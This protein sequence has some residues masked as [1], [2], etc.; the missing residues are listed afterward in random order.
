MSKPYVTAIMTCYNDEKYVAVA[1]KSL[2]EQTSPPDV[3]FVID[4]ASTDD[5]WN[6]LQ[7]LSKEYTSLHISQNKQNIGT[8]KSRNK[9]LG[10]IPE[11]TDYIVILDSDD[12]ARLDRIE[13][14]VL[15]LDSHP[16]VSAIN[17]DIEIIN[18]F[19]EVVGT[20]KHRPLTPT[21]GQAICW[22][23]FAQSA[24]TLRWQDWQKIGIYDETLR[25]GEDYDMW[26]RMLERGQIIE[27]LPQV[28]VQFRVHEGQGKWQKSQISMREYARVRARYL[29]KP[30]FFSVKALVI[31]LGY[32][33]ASFIPAK[34][35]LW[36]YTHLYARKES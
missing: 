29:F 34:I 15:Y 13:K 30:G 20:K 1:L 7:A 32:F 11:Q 27:I 4:D 3:V 33:A 19:G 8:V 36:L 21:T 10:L 14:Q 25:R 24:M 35:M 5:S 12:V 26:L 31:T 23:P 22:N 2:L 16:Y 28:L 18:Q 6:I 17:S 9:L